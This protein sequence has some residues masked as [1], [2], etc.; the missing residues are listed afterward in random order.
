M[1]SFFIIIYIEMTIKIIFLIFIV[2]YFLINASENKTIFVFEHFRHG[3]RSPSDL[4]KNNLDLIGEEW[5]GLQELS[6]VGLRQSYLLGHFIRN[7]YPSLINYEKY[8]PKEI[9]VLSTMTNRTIMSARAKLN[10]IFNETINNKIENNLIK[11]STPYYLLNELHKFNINNVSLYPDNFPEEVPVH[12]IDY[13]EKL[14]QLEKNNIC[15]I[16]KNIREKN[17]KREEITSFIQEFNSTFG[18][19]LLRI[20]NIQDYNYYMNYENVNDISIET[21]INKFDDR[22]FKRF[23]NRIDV[24]LLYNMSIKFFGLKTNLVYSNDINGTLG[25]IGSSILMR[26]ILSYME[27]IINNNNESPKLVL[28]ASHDTAIANMEGLLNNLFYTQ[29]IPPSYSSCFI[30]EL[31]K[32]EE[33]N[34]YYV[35]LIFN[36]KTLKTIEY[37]IFK[38]KIKDESWT[39]EK[40]GKYCGF[41]KEEDLKPNTNESKKKNNWIMIIIIFSLVN[42]LF[43]GF[44]SYLL[45]SKGIFQTKNSIIKEIIKVK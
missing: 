14:L 9:E 29:V 37:N 15:P 5:N 10:G 34:K 17:K 2:E 16:I 7:K 19:K 8:N 30:F 20:Y 43:I 6:Y 11:L 31:T 44:I 38:N 12:I 28:L 13:K 27:N 41:I 33:N 36:N 22:K 23:N 35:N 1:F 25:F 40:T 24:E 18:G 39:Y 3:A 21:I 45:I 42:I 4:S 26:K 32:N